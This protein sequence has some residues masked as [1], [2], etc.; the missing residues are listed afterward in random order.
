[1]QRPNAVRRTSAQGCECQFAPGGSSHWPRR[2]TSGFA[3]AAGIYPQS[4][5][6]SA[7]LVNPRDSDPDCRQS[8][9]SR[10]LPQVKWVPPSGH[11][12]SDRV[13]SCL[14]NAGL[15]TF[16]RRGR[17]VR[18]CVPFAFEG[19]GRP[20]P[21]IQNSATPTARV[22]AGAAVAH[23]ERASAKLAGEG[24]LPVIGIHPGPA[25]LPLPDSGW[26]ATR[27]S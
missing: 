9:V 10:T 22:A 13:A 7:P 11:L 6:S 8:Q 18:A 23:R 1:M 26:C 20:G 15:G 25:G 24:G 3:P 12:I 27:R 17:H 2:R 16:G 19:S 21:R 14:A 4:R 5:S